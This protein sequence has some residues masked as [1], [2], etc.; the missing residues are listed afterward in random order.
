MTTGTFRYIGF[1]KLFLLILTISGDTEILYLSS[2]LVGVG[3]VKAVEVV[4]GL[5]VAEGEV[6]APLRVW[7]VGA[8]GLLQACPVLGEQVLGLVGGKQDTNEGTSDKRQPI[9]CSYM[10][11]RLS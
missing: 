11:R 6:D 3:V 9:K 8:G 1:P 4:A 2:G 7:L 5:E 10:R